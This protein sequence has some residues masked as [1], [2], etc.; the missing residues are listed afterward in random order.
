MKN[1]NEWQSL[2]NAQKLNAFTFDESGNVWLK[3]KSLM[4][5]NIL[6]QFIA[7]TKLTLE[8]SGINNNFEELYSLYQNGSISTEVI[9]VFFT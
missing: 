7:T 5:K 4:R 8:T 6:T 1:F 3:I 9:D 2:F